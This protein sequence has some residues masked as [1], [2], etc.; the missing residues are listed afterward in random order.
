[1]S[2]KQLAFDVGPKFVP[3]F[4]DNPPQESDSETIHGQTK[5]TVRLRIVRVGNSC[6][7]E[8]AQNV[9]PVKLASA[10]VALRGKLL[11]NRVDDPI[12]NRPLSKPEIS[13]VLFQDNAESGRR[14]P[15]V[16]RIQRRCPVSFTEAGCTLAILWK[17]IGGLTD[18]G[19]NAA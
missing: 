15:A 12:L 17:F 7:R 9:R 8:H 11:L 6:T 1:M 5:A 16:H 3:P 13:W 2:V 19:L 18:P 10:F 14:E 4:S